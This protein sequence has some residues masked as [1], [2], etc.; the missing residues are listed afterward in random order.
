MPF[1]QHLHGLVVADARER[2]LD[3]FQFC[4]V[5]TN[6]D[7]VGATMLQD[8]LHDVGDEILGQLHDVVERRVGDFRLDHPELGEVA[9]RL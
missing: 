3:L 7:Q 1:V 6:G 2:R 5:A 4:N 9:P 8:V